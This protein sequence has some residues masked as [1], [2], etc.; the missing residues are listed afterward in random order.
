MFM[1]WKERMRSWP[2]LFLDWISSSPLGNPWLDEIEWALY[3]FANSVM[4]FFELLTNRPCCRFLFSAR[5][6]RISYLGQAASYLIV[7]QLRFFF[8]SK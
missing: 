6:F 5:S 8:F 4:L 2:E 3:A 7:F 1:R